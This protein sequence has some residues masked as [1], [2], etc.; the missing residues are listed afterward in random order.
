MTFTV[1]MKEPR[2]I[3]RIVLDTTGSARDYPRGYEVAVSNDG[4]KWSAPVAKGKGTHAITSIAFDA[5]NARYFRIT[6]TG[7]VNSLHWSIHEM[8]VF[9]KGGKVVEVAKVQ[10]KE[11]VLIHGASG[12]VGLAA[13]QLAAA[14]GCTVIGTA[15]TEAGM[16]AVRAAGGAAGAPSEL[17]TSSSLSAIMTSVASSVSIGSNTTRAAY[18]SACREKLGPTH[19]AGVVGAPKAE[20]M[21]PFLHIAKRSPGRVLS[22]DE[23]RRIPTPPS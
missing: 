22:T 6:Q 23:M 12:A 5:V 7:S 8:S 17:I 3:Y 13:T 2:N 9:E 21:L 18:A 16:A 14:H 4:E 1:D 11:S 10:P 15:G 20:C 19:T